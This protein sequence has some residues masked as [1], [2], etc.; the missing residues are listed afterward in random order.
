MANV[1]KKDNL[2]KLDYLLSTGVS[3]ARASDQLKIPLSDCITYLQ[4]RAELS[5][6]EPVT[7]SLL[8]GEALEVGLTGLISLAKTCMV[9]SVKLQASLELARLGIVL[10]EMSMRHQVSNPQPDSSQQAPSLWQFRNT[11][12]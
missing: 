12:S 9:P 3:L 7:A 6:I 5:R 2:N 4:K 11:A 8:A 10:K 1:T